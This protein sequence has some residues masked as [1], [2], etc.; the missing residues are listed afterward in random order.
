M[1]PVEKS[2]LASKYVGDEGIERI[3]YARGSKQ[4]EVAE[5]AKAIV[6][7]DWTDSVI[8]SITFEG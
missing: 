8:K 3:F 5:Q 2:V 6:L 7:T 4:S 1:N